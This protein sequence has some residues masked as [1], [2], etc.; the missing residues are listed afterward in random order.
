LQKSIS[1]TSLYVLITLVFDFYAKTRKLIGEFC[2]KIQL[3]LRQV[4]IKTLKRNQFLVSAA[5]NQNAS[6]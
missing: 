4:V 2:L 3:L 6:V 5:F 1:A